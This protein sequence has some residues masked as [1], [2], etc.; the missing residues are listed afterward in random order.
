MW[1]KMS[2]DVIFI[3]CINSNQVIKSIEIDN[4][5]SIPQGEIEIQ[6]YGEARNPTKQYDS[7]A[8]TL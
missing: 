5:I 1:K 8:F 7:E 3:T 2:L 4:I 6:R